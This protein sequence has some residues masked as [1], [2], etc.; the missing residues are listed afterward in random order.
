M[1]ESLL[2]PAT[3]LRPKISQI[4]QHKVFADVDWDALLNRTIP[5]PKLGPDWIQEEK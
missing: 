1:I 3:Y 5:P 2:N 4:K